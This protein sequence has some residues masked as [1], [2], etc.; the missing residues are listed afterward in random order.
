M[1]FL[2]TRVC[3]IKTNVCLQLQSSVIYDSG[4]IHHCCWQ[5]SIL[6]LYK[7]LSN[8]NELWGSLLASVIFQ[9]I[10]LQIT[11]AFTSK[12]FLSFFFFLVYYSLKLICAKNYVVHLILV[13]FHSFFRSVPG[14]FAKYIEV[15][16]RKKK[17]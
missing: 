5:R 15:N 12:V 8:S 4:Q 10:M 17:K 6:I 1:Y 14:D 11:M 7:D 2:V 9:Q 13:A 3:R 16:I